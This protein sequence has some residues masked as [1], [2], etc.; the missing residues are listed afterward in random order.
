MIKKFIKNNFIF[1]YFNK[2]I[3]KIYK[4]NSNKVINEILNKI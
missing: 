2:I 4:Q 3:I 1:L